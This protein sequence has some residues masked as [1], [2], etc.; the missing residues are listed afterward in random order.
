MQRLTIQ[1]LVRNSIADPYILGI[2][3]GRVGAT[4]VI[5]LGAFSFLGIYALSVSAFL[6][7]L[8]AIALVFSYH[9]LGDVSLFSLLLAGMAVSFILTAISNF[10]LMMSKQKG[11]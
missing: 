11:P 1:A 8:L 6:G 5:I 3:S 2:S 9:V 7:S 10:I 4:S